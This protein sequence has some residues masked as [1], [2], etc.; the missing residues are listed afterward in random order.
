MEREEIFRQTGGQTDKSVGYRCRK[1]RALESLLKWP[2]WR[3][4]ATFVLNI[5]QAKA[6][7]GHRDQDPGRGHQTT[8]ICYTFYYP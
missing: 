5:L 3:V 7:R 4:S 1:R 8:H 6:W 2:L